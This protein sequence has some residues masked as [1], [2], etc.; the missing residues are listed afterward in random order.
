M[1]HNRT[2]YFKSILTMTVLL[3]FAL[4]KCGDNG[5]EPTPPT[6]IRIVVKSSTDSSAISGANVVLYNANSGESVDREF[7]QSDGI[8]TFQAS[9][10]G[11]YYARIAAQGF[12]ELPEGSI[13]PVPF[14]VSS[15]QTTTQTYYMKN[16]PGTLEKLME[17]LILS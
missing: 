7:S 12:K 15:G 11:N 5:T 6:T 16:L 1:M 10:S 14:S 2:K 8:A 13:S 3:S 4:I 9:L 17:L